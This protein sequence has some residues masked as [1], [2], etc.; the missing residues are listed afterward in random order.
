[1]NIS[2]S[3]KKK[4][5]F[6]LMI[7]VC[8]LV[9]GTATGFAKTIPNYKGTLNEKLDRGMI[10]IHNGKGEV[11][12]SWRLFKKDA[13]D[14]SFDLYRT[15]SGGKPIKLN[16]APLTTSTYYIDQ[17]VDTSTDQ[18]YSLSVHRK[19]DKEGKSVASYLL[20]VERA[21]K[22]YL[23]IPLVPLTFESAALYEPN[24]ASVGDLDGDGELEIVLKRMGAFYACSQAGMCPGGILL[25]GCTVRY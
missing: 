2:C 6:A 13:P 8:T 20:S 18:L 11:S 7:L 19:D 3:K 25:H 16:K 17:N 4:Q 12:V 10:A 1:M 14:I 24:D 15:P 21:K 22:P 5:L 23:S 9:W